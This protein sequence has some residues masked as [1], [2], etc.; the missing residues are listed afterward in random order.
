MYLALYAAELAGLLF[1]E[2]DPHPEMFDRLEGTLL[3]L[4]T[5]RAEEAFLAFQL[6]LLR[7]SGYLPE[8]AACV[9]CGA[10][11]TERESWY[12]SP[13]RGGV[14]CRN[15]EA[16]TPDRLP[17]DARLLGLLQT[18]LR[19]PKSNGSTQ[20]LPRLTRHQT[21]PINRVFAGHM[22]H[23]LGKKLRLLD[24]VL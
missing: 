3:E 9:N 7:E 17:L 6:D 20:R 18:I 19:L 24:Y 4:G 23:T 11:P 12:F 21:D 1:E 16:A 15:C 10:L 5:L 2:H 14:V 13:L 22:Q 8:M